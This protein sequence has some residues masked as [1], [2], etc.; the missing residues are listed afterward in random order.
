[1][2]GE[3]SGL[4]RTR[5]GLIVMAL[6]FIIASLLILSFV[7][8]KMLA[9]DLTVKMAALEYLTPAAVSVRYL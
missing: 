4:M 9:Q 7:R 2:V 5:G 6:V 3:S 1:M 8:S